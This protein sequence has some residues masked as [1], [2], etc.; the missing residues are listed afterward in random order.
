MILIDLTSVS[1]SQIVVKLIDYIPDGLTDCPYQHGIISIEPV[2]LT[3]DTVW[4]G[5]VKS[6]YGMIRIAPDALGANFPPPKMWNAVVS[7]LENG[8][9]I[10]SASPIFTG[11]IYLKQVC[12]EYIEY[13]MLSDDSAKMMLDEIN[14]YD[15]KAMRLCE[16]RFY[17][18]STETGYQLNTY[19][20]GN[21]IPFDIV[22]EPAVVLE[23]FSAMVKVAF[24][25]WLNGGTWAIEDDN[26]KKYLY[27]QTAAYND[28][29]G[30]F[31]Y[32]ENLNDSKYAWHQSAVSGV[33]YITLSDG[34]NP[35]LPYPD[36]IKNWLSGIKY[37]H[38]INDLSQL[39]N[40]QF[41]FGDY[42]SLG[43]ETVYIKTT[44]GGT[45]GV[46]PNNSLYLI[47]NDNLIALYTNKVVPVPKAF[48]VMEK[49]TPVRIA[50][51]NHRPTYS[52]GGLDAEFLGCPIRDIYQDGTFPNET[53]IQVD[54][55]YG[56]LC[57]FYEWP[58]V[59]VEGTK[60]Y[61][62]V[63]R[64]TVSS[65]PPGGGTFTIQKPYRPD[66]S[67]VR[68]VAYRLSSA[69]GEFGYPFRVFDDGVPINDNVVINEVIGAGTFSL[70]ANPVGEVTISGVSSL[71]IMLAE[72]FEWACHAD[73]LNLTLNHD[74]AD[75]MSLI[76]LNV[77]QTENISIIDFLSEIA[78]ACCH[79]FYIKDGTLTLVSMT[80]DNGSATLSESMD[81]LDNTETGY[82]T[83]DLVS[84]VKAG[85][86]TSGEP[87]NF[88]KIV[89]F[90]NVLFKPGDIQLM[91]VK[92]LDLANR[93]VFSCVLPMDFGEVKIGKK[94]TWTDTRYPVNMTVSMRART[95]KYD[96]DK[97]E[98]EVSGESS[99]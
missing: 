83:P 14:E 61:D 74:H 47:V 63:Y 40:S 28:P 85:D 87:Y 82:E 36:Y 35:K 68:G 79:C 45:P 48:G 60:Y 19:E 33:W 46:S 26:G 70:T 69:D 22:S 55:D 29:G 90:K 98:I 27:V 80:Q 62:G 30:N 34:K 78:A 24:G 51:M 5:V 3:T 12:P 95:L 32:Q 72:V 91:L 31:T 10:E 96:Y 9:T 81:L 1:D 8:E 4:G 92:A 6:A 37:A 84:Q 54:L 44:N 7:V 39:Q 38:G 99:S 66:Y 17:W 89:D 53:V 56:S 18:V 88:G 67:P 23:N 20:G 77:W 15:E 64:S 42:S 73:R 97:Y 43:F 65:R 50:D 59:R 57:R 75:D 86:Q 49:I 52:L 71:G 25:N 41:I 93:D 2:T 16:G 58:Y 11:K 21:Y 94:L 13:R 76:P